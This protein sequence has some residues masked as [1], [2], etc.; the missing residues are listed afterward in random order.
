MAHRIKARLLR[1]RDQRA[2]L[3]RRP[4]QLER[5]TDVV[6][7]EVLAKGERWS[8][9]KQHAHS[10]GPQGLRGVLEHGAGLLVRYPGKPL[11]KIRQLRPIFQVL[12]KRGHRHSH[13]AEHPCAAEALGIPLDGRA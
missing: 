4:I 7:S 3:E 1:L 2:V 6:R 11:E 5:G 10:R 12:E 13:A 8:L 9:V